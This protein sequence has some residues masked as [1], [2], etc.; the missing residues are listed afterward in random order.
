MKKKIPQRH[1]SIKIF[2]AYREKDKVILHFKS[3]QS[4]KKFMEWLNGDGDVYNESVH[5]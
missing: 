2:P 4:A 1:E 5:K 3:H